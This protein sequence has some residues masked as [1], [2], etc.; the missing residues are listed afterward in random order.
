MGNQNQKHRTDHTPLSILRKR[1]N[2]AMDR[3]DQYV[4]ST[5]TITVKYAQNFDDF[6]ANVAHSLRHWVVY[7]T[8]GGRFARALV[9]KSGSLEELHKYWGANNI[10][11]GSTVELVATLYRR[12]DPLAFNRWVMEIFFDKPRPAVIDAEADIVVVTRDRIEKLRSTAMDQVLGIAVTLAEKI[13]GEE[14]KRIRK[15]VKI[16]DRL[17]SQA[18]M[19]L[20]YYNYNPMRVY[21]F[22]S[23]SKQ[24]KEMTEKTNGKMPFD[25]YAP[26]ASEDWRT[27]PFRE[28]ANKNGLGDLVKLSDAVMRGLLEYDRRMLVGMNKINSQLSQIRMGGGSV[29]KDAWPFVE[30]LQ[31]LLESPDHLYYAYDGS[32]KDRGIIEK[33]FR[34][35]SG[36]E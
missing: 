19:N 27:Y 32:T 1:D 15:L 34:I 21:I 3:R 24:K 7:R 22:H 36:T 8:D 12:Q 30:H 6:A 14:G 11:P 13:P 17:G 4:A 33:V 26:Y 16:A 20:W 31:K 29:Y 10:T 23:T 28:M 18:A 35:W 25:G 5:G 9:R 2:A